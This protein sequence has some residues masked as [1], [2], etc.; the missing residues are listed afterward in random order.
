MYIDDNNT[1]SDQPSFSQRA[2]I[3]LDSFLSL[4]LS[5]LGGLVGSLILILFIA[6]LAKLGGDDDLMTLILFYFFMIS[7]FTMWY[8][9]KSKKFSKNLREWNKMYF[10]QNYTIIFN[11]TLPKRKSDTENI[12]ELSKFI[13]PELRYDYQKFSPSPG[14]SL[15]FFIKSKFM[16]PNRI[17][18]K[19]IL[20]A[21]NFKVNDYVF[22]FA[23]KTEKG[24]FIITNFQD[25]F[26]NI[27]DILQIIHIAKSKFKTKFQRT[28]IFRLLIVAKSYDKLFLERESLERIMTNEKLSKVKIDLIVKE[29]IGYSV[30]WISPYI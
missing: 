20:K 25:K 15:K 7:F 5:L 10:D 27:D 21:T 12:I 29:N 11:T 6:G 3:L 26:V 18:E 16:E 28:Y 19:R 23:L 1:A 17:E 2:Y 8:F 22:D 30:L 14:D 13:F 4:N 24:Y 9:I